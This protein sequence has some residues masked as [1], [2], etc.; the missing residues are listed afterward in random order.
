MRRLLAAAV[1][2]CL[3]ADSP[4][5]PE[6]L[7]ASTKALL[8][9]WAAA[10]HAG[11]ASAYL[12]FYNQ[13]SFK[14]QKRT[15]S[16]E[17][18][19]YSYAAWAADRTRMLKSNPEVAVEELRIETWRDP[20][21]KLKPNVIAV[22]FLQR[23]RSPRYADHGPKIMQL[24]VGP[25]GKLSIIYE[26]LLQSRPGWD[27]PAGTVREL[28]LP[29]DDAEARALWVELKPTGKTFEE[30][31]ASIPEVPQLRRALAR[32]L[33]AGGNFEC[34]AIED[35]GHC[36]DEDWKWGPL[37]DGAGL[38]DGCL[39]RELAVWALDKG[40]LTAGEL[41]ALWPGLEKVFAFA[42]PYKKET[43][44]TRTSDDADALCSAVLTASAVSEK[45]HAQAI[46]AAVS[47]DCSATAARG[48]VSS[49]S[50]A[51]RVELAEAGVEEAF[52]GL[53]AKAH[54]ARF[55]SAIKDSRSEARGLGGGA[56][57]SKDSGGKAEFR[58]GLMERLAALGR[59]GELE[60][61]LRAIADEPKE[62]D[63][64][65]ALAGVTL[66][67]LGDASRLP[68]R[69]AGD[70]VA[71]F[72]RALR[73]LQHDPDVARRDERLRAFLPKKGKL[74]IHLV[75]LREYDG[76]TPPEE[77]N[78]RSEETTREDYDSVDLSTLADFFSPPS[79]MTVSLVWKT[80]GG[81]LYLVAI[82]KE[83]KRFIGCPC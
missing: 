60:A 82:E 29:K 49:L 69:P 52:A 71:A 67:A 25:D 59:N 80:L 20:G 5:A 33:L 12:G 56:P 58:I 57:A 19:E 2:F 70:D 47:N 39:R 79:D 75:E 51:R 1:L 3:A 54:R 6:A 38:D 30:V 48:E 9:S 83:T 14:G 28:R 46:A 34:K 7:R 32:A 78:E 61:A 55:L 50:L 24:L 11:D 62:D 65:A 21:S 36:G 77:R 68:K 40:G 22:S 37:P 8:S 15:T 63:R 44:H 17:K 53:D 26:A 74:K 13:K 10:Q 42:T 27:R 76:N 18:R 66:A 4:P 73:R 41:E 43:Q 72:E 64:V 23:W 35:E 81:K 45:L 16:G 31:L